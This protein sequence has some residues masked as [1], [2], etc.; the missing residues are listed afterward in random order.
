M[1]EPEETAAPLSGPFYA[2]QKEKK[3][4]TDTDTETAWIT[5][6]E[7]GK[8]SVCGADAGDALARPSPPP[9]PPD[10]RNLNLPPRCGG[11]GTKLALA[12]NERECV[13]GSKRKWAHWWAVTGHTSAATPTPEGTFCWKLPSTATQPYGGGGRCARTL[14]SLDL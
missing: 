3:H 12:S 13:P 9:S 11:R 6:N 10:R 14:T 8:S 4:K 2:R 7:E 5:H 1:P